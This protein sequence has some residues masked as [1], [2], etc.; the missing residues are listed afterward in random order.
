[1]QQVPRV[2]F[3]CRNEEGNLQEDVITLA[4]GLRELG[5]P[6]SGNCDYW[7][8][9]TK[10]GDYL[11][12]HDPA[13][14]ADDADVVVVSYTWP[15]WIRMKTFDL[16]RRP[17]PEGLFKKGRRYKTVY[18]DNHDGHRTVSWE[19]E[20]RQFD[21]ILRSKLNHRAWHP[22]NMKP[23]VYGFTNRVAQATAGA[24]P[25]AQ[26]K[27]TVLVNYGASH[28]YPHGTRD[29]AAH[30]FEPRVQEILPIDRTKDDLSGEPGDAYDALMWR[31]TGFRFS[32]SY[33][34]RLK[35]SQAVACFCGELIPPMPYR[36]PECYLVGG[37][38]A[39]IRRAFYEMLGR[40][41]PRP[42]RSVQWDS[43]RF[44][45]TLCAGAVAFNI[46]LER[47][48]AEI[49]VMPRNWEHYIGV[50]FDHVDEVIERLATEM[51]LL[52]RIAAA[53]CHWALKNYSPK[54]M[55]KRFLTLT[56]L[57]FA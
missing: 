3:Y 13:V 9:S 24:P 53:G 21:L 27:R 39:K 46:D 42:A 2:Y 14:S 22:E 50:D 16:V 29:L 54:A 40:L 55:A 20:F 5:V 57:V 18:M 4:E 43:F 47:Y 37:N 12:R 52:A 7:Q 38:K 45:E 30:T 35:N 15:F 11:I 31:Q 17:L 19:P 56:G 26:R 36:R 10:Q 6:F 28:P 48:G 33:Y 32:R 25:F 1:M 8:E 41:D 44:W 23:W 34:E 49:P 51:E